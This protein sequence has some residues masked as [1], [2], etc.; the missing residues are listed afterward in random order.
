MLPIEVG[1]LV[2]LGDLPARLDHGGVS[3]VDLPRVHVARVVQRRRRRVQGDADRNDQADGVRQVAERG[4]ADELNRSLVFHD[5]VGVLVKDLEQPE[6][7]V[8]FP[9]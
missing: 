4:D 9:I 6:N 2:S 3:H 7:E 1:D 8:F 5:L